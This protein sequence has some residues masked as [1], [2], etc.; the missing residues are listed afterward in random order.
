MDDAGVEVHDLFFRRVL[1]EVIINMWEL[2]LNGRE[3]DGGIGM[4]DGEEHVSHF[5]GHSASQ[6]WDIL[7][8]DPNGHQ[9]GDEVLAGWVG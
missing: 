3:G 5:E 2:K 8:L 9:S 7:T 4:G 1:G 6:V